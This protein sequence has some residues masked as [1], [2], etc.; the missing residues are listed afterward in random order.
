MIRVN[1]Q[2]QKKTLLY[3]VLY[4]FTVADIMGVSVASVV[5]HSHAVAHPP[6][7]GAFL[8]AVHSH[9]QVRKHWSWND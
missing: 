1:S 6:V 7:T 5:G 9:S 4:V 2:I 3:N 8:V